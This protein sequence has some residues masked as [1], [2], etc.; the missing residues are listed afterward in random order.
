MSENGLLDTLRDYLPANRTPLLEEAIRAVEQLPG[1]G[2]WTPSGPFTAN[3]IPWEVLWGFPLTFLAD[4]SSLDPLRKKIGR[5]IG[6]SQLPRPSDLSE[7]S[8]AA[9]AKALG[10]RQLERVQETDSDTPDFRVWWEEEVIEMEVTKADRKETLDDRLAAI[11]CLR[12]EIRSFGRHCDIVVHVA[13]IP[14]KPDRQEILEA[15]RHVAPGNQIE[16]YG[17]WCVRAET[18]RREGNY[19]VAGGQSDP[20]PAWWPEMDVARLFSLEQL[21]GGPDPSLV[22]PQVRVQ[23][24]APF[25]SYVNAAANK[26]DH[27]QG[28]GSVPFVIALD[29]M[30]L[31]GAFDFLPRELPEYLKAWPRVSAVWLIHGPSLAFPKIG[32]TKWTLIQNPDARHQ[33]PEKMLENLHQK[34][35]CKTYDLISN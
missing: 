9:L 23:F 7:V 27:F 2:K 29:V 20:L 14:T 24:G 28:T 5:R 19:H 31:P 17:R 15:A 26:A 13:D 34:P 8:A 33:L 21:V 6:K 35:N 30:S 12:Y 25:T 1:V 22:H 18:P 32:W 16:E 10:A 4:V 3:M 11:E